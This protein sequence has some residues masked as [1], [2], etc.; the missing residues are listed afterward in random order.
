MS[1]I[2]EMLN[3][4]VLPFSSWDTIAFGQT[5]QK[6]FSCLS[7]YLACRGF[8]TLILKYSLLAAIM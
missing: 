8:I 5:S 1:F 3:F 6:I 2:V 4:E 7:T